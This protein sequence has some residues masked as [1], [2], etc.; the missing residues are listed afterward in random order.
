M[1]MELLLIVA[2]CAFSLLLLTGAME[3]VYA[4]SVH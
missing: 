3:Q 1:K 2:F 4:H